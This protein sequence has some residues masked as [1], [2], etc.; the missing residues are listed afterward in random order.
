MLRLLCACLLVLP[1]LARADVTCAE[2]QAAFHVPPP[3]TGV[4]EDPD[5]PLGCSIEALK[6]FVVNH[7]ALAEAVPVSDLSDLHGAWLG[8]RVFPY[9]S[10]IRVAGQ[11]LLVFAPGP[12]PDTVAVTQYWMKAMSGPSNA[13][14][15]DDGGYVGVATEVV[16]ERA[17]DGKFGVF[18]SGTSI[19]YGGLLLE[20]ERS[21]DLAVKAQ[22]NH[23]ELP[24]ALRLAGDVLVLEGAHREPATRI[25]VDYARSYTRVAPGAAEQALTLVISFSLSQ[26][27]FFDCL[28]HQISNGAGPLYEAMGAADVSAL[29]ALTRSMIANGR[30]RGEVVSAL[31][32]VEDQDKRDLL[33][34]ELVDWTEAYVALIRTPEARS[35]MD[36]FNEASGGVCPTFN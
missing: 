17:G 36:R 11:E 3:P 19:R 15:S 2:M 8:D 7:S 34:Q 27:R 5:G 1:G 32:A 6:M 25:P 24:F 13:L 29:N 16:L 10:G 4:S 18:R 28:T 30:R 35:L 14:W 31:E 22:L 12:E 26:A 9:L 33:R 20:L 21:R 23:F